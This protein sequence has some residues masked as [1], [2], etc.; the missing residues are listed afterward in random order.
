[1]AEG[2]A[3]FLGKDKGLSYSAGSKP[4]GE[5]NE[6]AIKVMKEKGIDIS[7]PRS[8]GFDDLPIKDFYYVVTMGCKDTCPFIPAKNH[9]DWQIEDPKGKDIDFFRKVWDEIKEKV[10]ELIEKI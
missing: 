4:S 3:N 10:Y 9:L 5:V 1:M 2:F 8:K 7:N 6:L